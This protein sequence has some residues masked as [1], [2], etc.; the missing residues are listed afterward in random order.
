MILKPPV[1]T[2]YPPVSLGRESPHRLQRRQ[3]DLLVFYRDAV[4]LFAKSEGDYT[5]KSERVTSCEAGALLSPERLVISIGPDLSLLGPNLEPL[6]EAA[7]LG[8]DIVELIALENGR[9]LS[10]DEGGTTACWEL[11]ED[12]QL[13]LI[14]QWLLKETR[15]WILTEQHPRLMRMLWGWLLRAFQT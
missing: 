2:N 12:D 5:L 3:N 11:S 15:I 9:F 7:G 4:A 8:E 13:H 6:S 10:Q 14:S 1:M